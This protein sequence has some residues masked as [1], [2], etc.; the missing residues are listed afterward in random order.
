MSV[1]P[2]GNRMLNSKP[3][4][5]EITNTESM[6]VDG[7]IPGSS[8][9]DGEMP[10]Q[11]VIANNGKGVY[12]N[13]KADY[14]FYDYLNKSVEATFRVDGETNLGDVMK[15][16]PDGQYFCIRH[17]KGIWPNYIAELFKLENGEAVRVWS[18]EN[19][20][21]FDFDPAT[22]QFLYFKNGIL[23]RMSVGDL[24][25]KSEITVNEKYFYDIDWNNNEYVSLNE[26]RNL[27]SIYDLITGELKK[28]IKTFNFGDNTSNFSSLFI[29]IKVL[30]HRRPQAKVHLLKIRRL[31]AKENI[32]AMHK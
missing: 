11:F 4:Q 22:G 28:E 10:V 20:G 17:I 23:T 14:Y 32:L 26:D 16:A 27:I 25:V 18:S 7:I 31:I 9:P 24:T 29:R 8:F 3:A 2:D 6:E 12:Y 1:S 13:Q 19:V 5:L 15:I 21:F 30:F